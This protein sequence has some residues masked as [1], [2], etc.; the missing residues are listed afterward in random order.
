MKVKVS[1]DGSLHL[2]CS[3]V[4]ES[5]Q[6]SF[7]ELRY[8][9]AFTVLHAWI[10]YLMYSIRLIDKEIYIKLPKE[11]G[12][13]K[14]LRFWKSSRHLRDR[15]IPSEEEY[16]KIMNFDENRNI[17]VHRLVYNTYGEIRK[18]K[19]VPMIKLSGEAAKLAFSEGLTICK[20][21]NEKYYDLFQNNA[22]FLKDEFEYGFVYE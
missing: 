12:D 17:I 10:D 18:N 14:G 21:L 2:D 5:A 19:K 8:I 9:E 6:E 11:L 16:S 20:M 7:N 1:E 15:K 13:F 3:D 22:W 4:V